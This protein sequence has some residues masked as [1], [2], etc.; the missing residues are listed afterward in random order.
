MKKAIKKFVAWFF[1]SRLNVFDMIL[2]LF[3]FQPVGMALRDVFGFWIA[4][5]MI[6]AFALLWSFLSSLCE[7]LTQGWGE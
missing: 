2:V 6:V 3:F 1:A 7:Y 4:L 5:P